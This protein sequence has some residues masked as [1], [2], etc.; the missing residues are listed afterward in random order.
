MRRLFSAALVMLLG[1]AFASAQ[2]K[3]VVLIG[4]GTY[5]S[6]LGAR[7]VAELEA[8][9]PGIRLVAPTQERL[10]AELA[11]ADGVIGSVNSEIMKAAP[12]LQWVQVGYAGVERLLT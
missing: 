12:K 8:A 4:S 6:S 3:K 11:D 1:V 2:Q 7:E 10:M 5:Y 9:A